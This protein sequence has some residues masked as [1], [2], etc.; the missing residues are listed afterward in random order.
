V[1]LGTLAL[2]VLA[3]IVMG[4]GGL[5][6]LRNLLTP[7]CIRTGIKKNLKRVKAPVRR[8]ANAF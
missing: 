5:L 7:A 4:T 1:V 8:G 3:L 2:Y 6:L